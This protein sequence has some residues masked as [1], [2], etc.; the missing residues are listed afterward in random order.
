M[1]VFPSSG[2][3]TH[4][5]PALVSFLTV[6]QAQIQQ[7]QQDMIEKDM[8][9]KKKDNKLRKKVDISI[10]ALEKYENS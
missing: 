3:Y 9:Q 4:I 2:V 6:V 10:H 5:I 7:L 8:I 1:G